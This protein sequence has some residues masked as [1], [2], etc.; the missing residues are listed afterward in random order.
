MRVRFLCL[1]ICVCKGIYAFMNKY[2]HV[3]THIH[4]YR[5]AAD[6]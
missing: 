1:Y 4:I 3:Y 2:V 5:L 6:T